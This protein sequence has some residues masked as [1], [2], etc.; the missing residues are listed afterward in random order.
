MYA[1]VY[2]DLIKV[3][4]ERLWL[5]CNHRHKHYEENVTQSPYINIIE[6]T[7]MKRESDAI[8]KVNTVR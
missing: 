7:T 6:V 8:I 3:T 5:L 1:K 2:D 4:L